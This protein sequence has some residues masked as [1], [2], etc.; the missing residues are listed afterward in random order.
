MLI[1]YPHSL[2]PLFVGGLK[3][4]IYSLSLVTWVFII[5]VA[6]ISCCGDLCLYDVIR[7]L[8]LIVVSC[9]R[10]S[11]HLQ[12]KGLICSGYVSLSC[13]PVEHKSHCPEDGA[14]GFFCRRKEIWEVKVVLLSCQGTKDVPSLL[15]SCWVNL[16]SLD[17]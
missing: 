13:N 15:T 12:I 14:V 8:G 17:W 9:S 1:L 2:L 6:S 5:Y 16:G 11:V 3:M 4:C 10:V 7:L